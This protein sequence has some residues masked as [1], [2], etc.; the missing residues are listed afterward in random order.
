MKAP[1]DSASFQVNVLIELEQDADLSIKR[2][3]VNILPMELELNL[4]EERVLGCLIEKEMA[5]PEYYPLTLNALANACNQKSNRLPVMALDESTVEHALYEM[6]MNRKL[7]VEVTSS[8]N[9]V[10]KYRHNMAAHWN[11]S[12]AKMAILCELLI[13]GP[14]TPGDLRAHASRLHPMADAREVEEI[15]QGLA[16]HSDGPFVIHL[17]RESGKRERRW[18]HLFG[19]EPA[20]E[21]AQSEMHCTP[22]AQSLDQ[23]NPKALEMDIA[24]LR[25]ELSNLK[26]AFEEFRA[27]FE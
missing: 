9:R 13:R 16:R 10:P 2:E 20:L 21:E 23:P 15:L 7:A 17:P 11:F 5:T 1:E 22:E 14:Q 4:I 3:R 24:K 8:G 19:G 25:E 26:T 18:A 6:R 12:P 27:R